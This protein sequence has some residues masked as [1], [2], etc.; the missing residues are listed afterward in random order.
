MLDDKY[1]EIKEV[2]FSDDQISVFVCESY[3][4]IN[5]TADG[6][7]Y[8]GLIPQQLVNPTQVCIN[9]ACE[10]YAGIR[11]TADCKP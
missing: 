3:A 11:S 2:L 5:R 7:S 4:G 6:I 1:Y 8:V 9:A 10:S